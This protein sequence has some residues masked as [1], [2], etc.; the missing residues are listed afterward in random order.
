[1]NNQTQGNSKETNFS[2]ATKKFINSRNRKNSSNSTSQKSS[3][4]RWTMS[5]RNANGKPSKNYK[6]KCHKIRWIYGNSPLTG[7]NSPRVSCFSATSA[8]GWRRWATN[9]SVALSRSSSLWW[10]RSCWVDPTL[11]RS[12]RSWSSCWMMTHKSLWS[13]YGR[14]WCWSTW[15][16]RTDSFDTVFIVSMHFSPIIRQLQ[17]RWLSLLQVDRWDQAYYFNTIMMTIL[18]CN[19][20]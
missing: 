13:D 6:R 1:M 2:T 17:P 5:K 7:T 20:L 19:H 11:T 18:L 3:M 16:C 14:S 12:S 8:P 10:R 4:K 15:S 9:T